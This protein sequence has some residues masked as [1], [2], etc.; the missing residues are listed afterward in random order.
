MTM[1]RCEQVDRPSARVRSYCSAVSGGELFTASA[2]SARLP[3]SAL[4]AIGG[5]AAAS[6]ALTFVP[7]RLSCCA[8]MSRRI[9]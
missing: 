5:R 6:T 3:K 9:S 7:P 8:I 2:P 1:E 4:S